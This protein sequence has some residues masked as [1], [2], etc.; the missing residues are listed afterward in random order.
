MWSIQWTTILKCVILISS[1]LTTMATIVQVNPVQ[2]FNMTEASGATGLSQRW[3]QWKSSFNFYLVATGVTDDKQKRALLLHSAGQNVQE[4]F[5][6]L[7]VEGDSFADCVKALDTYFKPKKN[8]AFER[9]L[10]RQALQEESETVDAY[11]TRLRKLIA[12]CENPENQCEDMIRD[13]VIENCK[14]KQLRVRL[15]HKVDLKLGKLLDMARA[16]EAAE[17]QARLMERGDP[18]VKVNSVR[19]SKDHHGARPRTSQSNRVRSQSDH[20]SRNHSRSQ[21]DRPVCFVCG[22]P[23]HFKDTCYYKNKRCDTCGKVGHLPSTCFMKND[24]KDNKFKKNNSEQSK[25]STASAKE[26]KFMKKTYKSNN[27]VDVDSANTCDIQCDSDDSVFQLHDCGE[28]SN[29]LPMKYF[30]VNGFSVKC[31]VDSGATCNIVNQGVVNKINVNLKPCNKKVKLYESDKV[32]KVEGCFDACVKF[33]GSSVRTNFL[34]VNSGSVPLIG[35]RTAVELGV[36]KM[37][38]SPGEVNSVKI[39]RESES[40]KSH[41]FD[42]L[43]VKYSKCFEGV[44]KLKDF[45][46]DLHIDESVKPVAQPLRRLPYSLRKGVEKKLQELLDLDIIESVQGPS[47]WVS[48]P[49]VVPKNGNVNDIRLCIDMRRANEAILRTRHPIP[50]VEEMLSDMSQAALF[51]KLDLKWGFHQIELSEK[52]RDVTTFVTHK[53]LFRFKRLLFGANAAPEEYQNILQ[54][55]L[56]HCEGTRV[57]ADDI[58][59]FGKDAEEHKHRLE[60]VLQTLCDRN[61][62]LNVKKCSFGLD[63]IEFM[64]HV[65]SRDGLSPTEAKVK[66]ITHAKRP[67]T[68]SK[69]EVS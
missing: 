12:T 58:V 43:R 44:G 57:I 53:G 28:M 16:Q 39:G 1:T 38:D 48:P 4:L 61:L 42:E 23:G 54:Q 8:V 31:L 68:A 3:D 6:T 67:A 2:P 56:Q 59:V 64:G 47:S 17:T 55:V 52:S 27:V 40:A 46:L 50:T 11:V 15:L 25:S 18:T 66:A 32:V 5:G 24:K 37:C 35:Y 7:T 51:S 34:V 62:T 33:N 45:Q 65:L 19:T 29:V 10:F 9:H 20:Q 41:D 26:N 36:L 49:V 22:K 14:F 30:D 13:Q 21:S 60:K 69:C 63:R